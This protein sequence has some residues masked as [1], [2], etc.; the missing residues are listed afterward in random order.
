MLTGPDLKTLK[1]LLEK[2][3]LNIIASGGVASL[4]HIEQ[5]LELSPRQ[6]IGCIIGKAIYTGAI[7]LEKAIEITK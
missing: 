4:K 6:P 5:L 7:N 1:A 2:T 3:E